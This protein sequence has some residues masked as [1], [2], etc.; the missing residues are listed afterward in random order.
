M[1]NVFY[2][3]SS[4]DGVCTIVGCGAV[5]GVFVIEIC[6]QDSYLK[7]K[8][9]IIHMDFFRQTVTLLEGVTSLYIFTNR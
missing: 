3:T 8:S 9:K 5:I 4:G 6:V 2:G 7:C 1:R